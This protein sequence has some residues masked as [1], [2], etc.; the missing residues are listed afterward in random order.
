M[1]GLLWAQDP[2]ADRGAATAAAS[3]QVIST[4]MMISLTTMGS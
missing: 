3:G 2:L 1:L 4:P